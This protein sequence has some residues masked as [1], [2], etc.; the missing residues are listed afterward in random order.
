[1]NPWDG[2]E[3]ERREE[4]RGEERGESPDITCCENTSSFVALTITQIV[5]LSI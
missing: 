1:M 4:R 3:G 2:R 5:H